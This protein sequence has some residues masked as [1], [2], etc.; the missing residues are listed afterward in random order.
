MMGNL[1]KNLKYFGKSVVNYGK[2]FFTKDPYKTL[3]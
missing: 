2:T 1:G 3:I